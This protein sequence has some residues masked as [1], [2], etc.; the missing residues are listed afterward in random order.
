MKMWSRHVNAPTIRTTAHHSVTVGWNGAIY[1]MEP[2]E[3]R[4]LAAALA[5]AVV[6]LTPPPP[7]GGCIVKGC[8]QPAVDGGFW[9]GPDHHDRMAAAVGSDLHRYNK[10]ILDVLAIVEAFDRGDAEALNV[11][12]NSP[13]AP[14]SF[15]MVA[16][17][18]LLHQVLAHNGDLAE[19][20]AVWR[21]D[22]LGKLEGQL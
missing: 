20:V 13:S 22:A 12:A 7:T 16:A 6:A 4:E 17:C 19:A 1:E 9:C 8:D 10:G 3:A 11:V 18:E 21:N 5:A 14:P 2:S 15:G